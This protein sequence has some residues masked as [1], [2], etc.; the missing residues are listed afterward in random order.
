[1]ITKKGTLHNFEYRANVRA[2]KWLEHLWTRYT[3]N[4]KGAKPIGWSHTNANIGKVASS[5]QS[6]DV[7]IATKTIC[8]KFHIGITYSA[9]DFKNSH[10]NIP[11]SFLFLIKEL[12]SAKAL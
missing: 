5:A 1:M 11:K 8:I 2:L 6:L 12:R 3:V 10:E 7:E 4:V 9:K